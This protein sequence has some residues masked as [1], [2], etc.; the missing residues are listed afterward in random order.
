MGENQDMSHVGYAKNGDVHLAYKVLG[1]GDI[2]IMVVPMW[3]SNLDLLPQHPVMARS[4]EQITRVARVVLWDR[5]G[6]GLSDRLCGP[7]TLEEGMDDLIAVLDASGTEKAALFGFNEAGTLC[8]LA[9]AT[10]PD[11]VSGLILY[12][13]YAATTWHADYPWGQSEEERAMQIEWICENW[14]SEEVSQVMMAGLDR[15]AIEWARRWQ[16]L[17]LSPD[18]L[19]HFYEMLAKTD[20][21]AILPSIRVPTLI[22]H[23]KDDVSVPVDNGRYLAKAIPGARY[24]EL[25]GAVH[26]PFFSDWHEIQGEIEEFLTGERKLSGPERV[27]ATI[28]FTDIVGS[29]E[30]AAELGDSRWRELLDLHDRTARRSVDR[31]GGRLV[32]TIGDG[33]LATFDGPARAIRCATGLRDEMREHG[34]D[35]RAGVHT[36]EV[37]VI[38][39]DIG[40]IAVHIGARVS[41]LAEAGEVLVSPAVPPLVAGSGLRFE[42]R[43]LRELKGVDGAW[44]LYAVAGP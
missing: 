8:A 10:R 9:A 12:G 1:E 38:G 29:T 26:V 23:R 41:A 33:V 17:S 34:L 14:G 27:L 28:L 39:E 11:R 42:D 16:S 3:F 44:N 18:A 5:R 32:K 25:E 6:S 43:G 37:E 15:S 7:A 30:R 24:V 21:R 22:M 35:L 2:T 20:V 36:G 31:Y 19:P 4:L 13:S 40:G